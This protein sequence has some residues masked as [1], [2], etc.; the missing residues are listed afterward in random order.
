MRFSVADV[1]KVGVKR[2]FIMLSVASACIEL[3]PS[4][5]TSHVTAH[6]V[7]HLS[8]WKS[9]HWLAAGGRSHCL[10]AQS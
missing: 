2:D 1:F 9:R 7:G 10:I 5:S 3:F 6:D 4:P 8:C